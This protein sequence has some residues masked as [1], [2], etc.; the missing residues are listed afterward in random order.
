MATGRS[1]HKDQND[2]YVFF[3]H[4]QNIPFKIR[5]L[6]HFRYLHQAVKDCHILTSQCTIL[7]YHKKKIRTKLH[8]QRNEILS[9]EQVQQV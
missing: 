5:Y 9:N 1:I 4:L 6:Q 2:K 7:K 3:S 8:H